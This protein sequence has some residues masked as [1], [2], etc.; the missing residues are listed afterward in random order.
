MCSLE[1]RKGKEQK[2]KRAKKEPAKIFHCLWEYTLI[3]SQGSH[4]L[5]FL[6]EKTEVLNAF[7]TPVFTSKPSLE[8]Q[9][10]ETRGKGR[11]KENVPSVE[12][13]QVTEY[14][15]KLDIM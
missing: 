8:C 13:V 9:L 10:P 12:K 14:L 6:L 15:S 7:F 2:G 3:S 1:L 4:K 11:S 5:L